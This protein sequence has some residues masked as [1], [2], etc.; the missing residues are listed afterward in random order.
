MHLT[1]ITNNL[2]IEWILLLTYTSNFGAF[3][4]K[5]AGTDNFVSEFICLKEIQYQQ[6]LTWLKHAE[7]ATISASQLE[8]QSLIT[9]HYLW[10]RVLKIA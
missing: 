8:P 6:L 4:N 3:V 7:K 9:R 10:W 1:L 2:L 5:S